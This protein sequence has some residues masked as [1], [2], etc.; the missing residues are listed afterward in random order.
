[1][2]R[3]QAPAAAREIYPGADFIGAQPFAWTATADSILQKLARLCQRNF[4]DRTLAARN[5][6]ND[7]TCGAVWSKPDLFH[8]GLAQGWNIARAR[9]P[10]FDP[11][12]YVFAASH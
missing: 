8:Q 4:R 7:Y 10:S 2:P 9:F 12:Q 5:S 3:D 6:I 1:V 11:A